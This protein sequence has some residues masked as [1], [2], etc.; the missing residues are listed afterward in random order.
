MKQTSVRGGT[1]LLGKNKDLGD[2]GKVLRTGASDRREVG[3]AWASFN[4]RK[5][6]RAALFSIFLSFT[7]R[8]FED[9][10]KRE[11]Q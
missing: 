5:T 9:P 2:V 4:D 6:I 3:E 11:L 1:N 7:R 10:A 8:Y